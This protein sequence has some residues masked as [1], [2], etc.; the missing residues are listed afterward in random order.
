VVSSN[1]DLLVAPGIGVSVGPSVNN[2]YEYPLEG[3]G[4]Y[5]MRTIQLWNRSEV[6]VR[7]SIRA[8]LDNSSP[9]LG[10][11]VLFNGDW[12]LAS[13]PAS[14]IGVVLQPGEKRNF[15][16]GFVWFFDDDY[17]N[18]SNSG[19]W[20]KDIFD[21]YVEDDPGLFDDARDTAFGKAAAAYLKNPNPTTLEACTFTLALQLNVEQVD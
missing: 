6:V 8:D 19:S 16:Y 13:K 12:P 10:P 15:S 18:S 4:R 17:A 3:T 14:T 7:C 2:P 9:L 21:G 11:I 1:G 5:G 20:F